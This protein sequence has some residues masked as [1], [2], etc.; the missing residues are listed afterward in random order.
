M[1]YI[2]Y[3]SPTFFVFIYTHTHTRKTLDPAPLTYARVS[4]HIHFR[5]TFLL[6]VLVL[7]TLPFCTLY[8]ISFLLFNS[9]LGAYMLNVYLGEKRK[10]TFCCALYYPTPL[11][12]FCQVVNLFFSTCITEGVYIF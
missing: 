2:H 10:Y 3:C 6:F 11:H 12:F 7:Y 5:S 8:T 9:H 4:P 1:C